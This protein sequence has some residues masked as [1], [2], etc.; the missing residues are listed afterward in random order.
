MAQWPYE[1]AS[2]FVGHSRCTGCAYA[3]QRIG[4][5]A[6]GGAAVRSR[7]S[8]RQMARAVAGIDR[9]RPYRHCQCGAGNAA[10]RVARAI[11]RLRVE[12]RRGRRRPGAAL[13]CFLSRGADVECR[14][15]P[16]RL[17]QLSALRADCRS[18]IPA[19]S[20]A[21]RRLGHR[22]AGHFRPA[23][24]GAGVPDR[25]PG[26]PG[27]MLGNALRAH[28][29]AAHGRQPGPRIAAICDRG[30]SVAERMRCRLPSA[31]VCPGSC[32][33]DSARRRTPDRAR[34]RLH[35]TR[36]HL[37]HPQHA[38]LVGAYGQRHRG[39]GTGLWH[40]TCLR[41]AGRGAGMAH[42]DRC[43]ADRRRGVAGELARRSRK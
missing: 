24:A 10:S 25:K 42:T 6:R 2:C 36:A 27:I 30:R 20:A 41:A 31:G 11:R 18:D 26:R 17:R 13:D 1:R 32:V 22:R 15:R 3:T 39:T 8:V 4:F 33:A 9:A 35:R 16:A 23:V 19:T 43:G 5:A 34:R 12:A 38:R 7:R 21:P 40:R 29:R 28:V 37:V 14:R